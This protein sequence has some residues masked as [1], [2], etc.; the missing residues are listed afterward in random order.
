[1]DVP[2]LKSFLAEFLQSWEVIGAAI[3]LLIYCAIVNFVAADNS[4]FK[5]KKRLKKQK[6]KRPP[7]PSTKPEKNVDESELDL[8][9]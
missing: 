1:M 7:K 8:G 3:A 6:I 2:A 4:Q 5:E 9:E